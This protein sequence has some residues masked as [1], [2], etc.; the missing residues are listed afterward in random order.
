MN[1]DDCERTRAQLLTYLDCEDCEDS[2][3]TITA[4]LKSCASCQEAL[5]LEEAIRKVVRRSC[6]E[7]CPEELR[8]TISEQLRHQY[9]QN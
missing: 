5:G 2:R 3:E 7:P 4:H 9:G 8:H 1:Q 6:L